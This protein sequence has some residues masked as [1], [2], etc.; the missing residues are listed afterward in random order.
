MAINEKLNASIL[1]VEDEVITRRMIN[2]ILQRRFT[3]VLEAKDGREGLEL[4][5]QHDPDIV[6]T[7]SKM[8]LMDGVEMSRI[9]KSL[10]P[11]IPII[12]T[13]AY[14][15]PEFMEKLDE[16]GVR[17]R[18]VKPIDVKELLNTLECLCLEMK[19]QAVK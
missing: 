5:R 16:I 14:E 3:V 1:Y 19:Y 11:D 12:F 8:P 6:I 10:K 15:E 18:F 13:S 17:W 2:G 9:I 7:D 4:F